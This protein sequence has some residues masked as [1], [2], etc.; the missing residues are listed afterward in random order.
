M[1]LQPTRQAAMVF[2]CVRQHD[3]LNVCD[4][5]AE[6]MKLRSQRVHRRISFWPCIHERQRIVYDQVRVDGANGEGRGDHKF[7]DTHTR[8]DS[9]N[10]CQ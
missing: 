3:A 9:A 1:L 10:A 6:L 2:V 5:K 4:A 8:K 7:F